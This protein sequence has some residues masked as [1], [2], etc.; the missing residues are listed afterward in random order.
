ITGA[1]HGL[2]RELAYE[3]A[4][5]GAHVVCLDIDEGSNKAV[6]LTL[7]VMGYEAKGYKINVGDPT[8]VDT[9]AK[10]VKSRFGKVS[11]LVNNAGIMPVG[12]LTDISKEEI[13][14]AFKVNILSHFWVLQA[15]LPDMIQQ[16]KGHVVAISSMCGVSG[17]GEMATYCST[18]FA[19]RGNV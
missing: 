10:E 7:H 8:E 2:G 12:E 5:H 19:I 16:R 15:F 3:F 9:L 14:D 1:G 6:I 11:I 18:K 13:L 17:V 4:R